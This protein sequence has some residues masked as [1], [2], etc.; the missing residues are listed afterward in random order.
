MMLASMWRAPLAMKAALTRGSPQ[1]AASSEK[2][3]PAR[4]AA[5]G[6]DPVLGEGRQDRLFDD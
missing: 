4:G 2:R 6:L 3:A 5:L 1:V